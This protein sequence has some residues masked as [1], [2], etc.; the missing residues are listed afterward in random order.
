MSVEGMAVRAVEESIEKVGRLESNIM[1]NEKGASWD[2]DIIIHQKNDN[3]K[4]G[5]I[6]IPVQVKGKTCEIF[7]KTYSFSKMQIVDLENYLRDGGCVF[8]LVYINKTNTDIRKICYASLTPIEIKNILSNTKTA[9]KEKTIHL[10]EFP[11]DN[12]QKLNMFI[13]FYSNSQKQHS[14]ITSNL[15]KIGELDETGVDCIEIS[16]NGIYDAKTAFLND[17]YCMY[18]QLSHSNAGILLPIA[19][20]KTSYRFFIDDIKEKISIDGKIFYNSYRIFYDTKTTTII[21]GHSFIITV[22]KKNGK[23]QIIYKYSSNIRILV[24]DLEFIINFLEKGYF[25]INGKKQIFEDEIINKMSK[26]IN[27]TQKKKALNKFQSVVRLLDKIDCKENI[28]VLNL[29]EKEEFVLNLLY[30]FEMNSPMFF[31]NTCGC[32]CI[33]S[34]ETIASLRFKIRLKCSSTITDDMKYLERFGV[35]CSE[36]IPYVPDSIT[37]LGKTK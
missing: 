4:K 22:N 16:S 17:D 23:P 27:V 30:S 34:I 18:A 6:R 2:G 33:E 31:S 3:T 7:P 13:N 29:S 1:R 11:N 24:I 28:N 8:F 9:Q 14:F 37:Y 35:N 25:E 10:K 15:K 20:E 26:Q 21:I 19:K 32:Q 12:K 36:L 5:I